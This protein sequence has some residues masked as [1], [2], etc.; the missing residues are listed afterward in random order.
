MCAVVGAH[1]EDGLLTVVHLSHLK[2][3]ASDV[4][5]PLR[6]PSLS[7]VTELFTNRKQAGAHTLTLQNTASRHKISRHH[8]RAE[9]KVRK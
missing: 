3:N 1:N 6:V 4:V 2:M 7:K 9:L 5:K 8:N